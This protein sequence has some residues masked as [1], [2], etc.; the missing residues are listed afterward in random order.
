MPTEA[1]WQQHL[2]DEA[3]AHTAVRNVLAQLAHAKHP[4]TIGAHVLDP[5]IRAALKKLDQAV[6]TQQK[7]AAQAK[8]KGTAASARVG[9]GRGTSKDVEE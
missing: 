2:T 8:R 9:H 6:V 4:V 7:H 5:N 3:N 1:Q